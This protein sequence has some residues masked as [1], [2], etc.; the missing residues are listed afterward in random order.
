MKNTMKLTG[1]LMLFVFSSAATMFAQTFNASQTFIFDPGNTGSGLALWHNNIGLND[2][3][4]TANFGLRLVKNAAK[5]ANVAVGT[6][7]TGLHGATIQ[8]GE[9]L[10]YDIQNTSPC[11]GGSPRFNVSWFFNGGQGFSFVGGCGNDAERTLAPQSP[12]WTR[13]AFELQDPTESFPIIPVGAQ[14]N[15]ITLVVDETGLYTLDNIQ[16]RQLYADDTSDAGMQPF[17]P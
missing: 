10:G 8:N 11:T 15:R 13:V 12:N 1:F 17:C 6:T 2:S 5:S 9:T 7:I 3:S 14:I 4:C 16:F